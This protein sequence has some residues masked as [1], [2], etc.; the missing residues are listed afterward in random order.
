MATALITGASSGIGMEIAK[1]L[2][3]RKY[4]LV[5]T[6]RRE[7]K[8]REIEKL[9]SPHVK[10]TVLPFD[11]AQDDA[12]QQLFDALQGHPI[13]ILVNNAGFADFGAFAESDWKKMSAL[14]HVN[15]LA[16]TQLT[17][18]FL[19]QMIERKKGRILN[20]ASTAAFL[21]GPWMSVYY[22]SKAYVLS[23]SD[24]LA[25]E[26][27]RTGVSV[28][29]L[30]PGPTHSEFQERAGMQS[31]KIMEGALM[32]AKPV[33]RL[34]VAAMM[35]G[36]KTVVPGLFNRVLVQVPRFASRAALAQMVRKAQEPLARPQSPS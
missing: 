29:C 25:N 22:A 15:I 27:A 14:L 2:A 24:A 1:E 18:L 5:L 32:H 26:T 7:D 17:R 36:Q 16:L 30:C 21:P 3:R 9:L 19:P 11:L 23:F 12:P 10:I 28:T 13:D 33:A 20:V 35:R 6:A 31:S 34:G 8:L 4:D